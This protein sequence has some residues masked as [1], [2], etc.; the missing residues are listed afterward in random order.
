MT[1]DE[2]L[3]EILVYAREAFAGSQAII[4][5]TSYNHGLNTRPV[6]AW[7]FGHKQEVLDRMWADAWGDYA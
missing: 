2:A 1:G 4:W 3:E 5:A 6:D 7:Y